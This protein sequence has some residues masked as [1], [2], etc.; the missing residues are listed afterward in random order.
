MT[1]QSTDIKSITAI[2]NDIQ[3][4]QEF[5]DLLN[6]EKHLRI[7][8]IYIVNES[9]HQIE[10]IGNFSNEASKKILDLIIESR[11]SLIEK[12]NNVLKQCF[13]L[14]QLDETINTD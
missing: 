9:D 11:S 2:T 6:S 10:L 8:K 13:S 3:K 4:L 14:V 5:I 12:L 1:L 7:K